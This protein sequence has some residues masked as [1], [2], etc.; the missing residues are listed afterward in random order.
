M[1]T[2]DAL[3]RFLRHVLVLLEDEPAEDDLE[4][5]A[6]PWHHRVLDGRR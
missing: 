4:A 3:V 5:V 6:A 1:T 2:R